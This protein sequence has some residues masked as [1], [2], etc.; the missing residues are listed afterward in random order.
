M[1]QR[2]LAARAGLPQPSIA[3]IESGAVSPR[4]ETLERCLAACGSR[5]AVEPRPGAGIDRSAIRELLRL[6]PAERL[7]QA[8]VEAGNLARIA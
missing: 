1:S 3:R 6:S 4:M 8:V 2:E 7:A 5:L